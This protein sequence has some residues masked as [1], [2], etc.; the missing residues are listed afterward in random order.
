MQHHQ[1]LRPAY[2]YLDSQTV[3]CPYSGVNKKG[4]SIIL[5]ELR[6]GRVHEL[7]GPSALAFSLLM[8]KPGETMLCG[9][10]QSLLSL[11]P[12]NI[13]Q[14]CDPNAILFVPCPLNADVLWAAETAL[15]S[16]SVKNIIM[17]T[18]RSP[19]LTNFRRLHLAALNGK[20]LGLIIVNRPAHSTAA[21][22][23]WYCTPVS[24]DKFGEVCLH[25]SLYKNKK[26]TIGSWVINVFGE[27]NTLHLDAKPAGEPLWPSR[28]AG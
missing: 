5:P 1:P 20:S 9:P 3:K 8:V 26:G 6:R 22:T 11:H 21:E 12:E 18:Q 13:A 24:T 16:S 15:R 23:R 25:V 14:F 10:P 27:E 7:S 2:S 17:I 4:T 19:G 28:V